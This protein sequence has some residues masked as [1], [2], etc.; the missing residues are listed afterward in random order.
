LLHFAPEQRLRR[1][2]QGGRAGGDLLGRRQL[3][4]LAE[5]AAARRPFRLHL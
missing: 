3:S 5:L 1:R 4:C 2:R